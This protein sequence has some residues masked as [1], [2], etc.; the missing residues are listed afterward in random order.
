MFA[1][2]TTTL[3]PDGMP[4]RGAYGQNFWNQIAILNYQVGLGW[5]P[6]QYPNV[7]FFA[8]YVYEYWFQAAS[9]MTFVNP[10]TTPQGAS[11]GAYEMQGITL[12][13]GVNY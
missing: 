13:M 5:K 8:G 3:T 9:N 7:S 6:P 1:A 4:V 11:R 10:F 12:Q 2:S